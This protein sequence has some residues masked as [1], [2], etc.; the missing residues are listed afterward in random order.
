LPVRPMAIMHMEVYKS[1][2]RAARAAIAPEQAESSRESMW[3]LRAALVQ[4]AGWQAISRFLLMQSSSV[5]APTGHL[6]VRESNQGWNEYQI[7][8]RDQQGPV[9]NRNINRSINE[10]SRA[11]TKFYGP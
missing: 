2:K 5:N 11:R 9:M 3:T 7:I 6:R 10:H 8:Q 4:G 1:L